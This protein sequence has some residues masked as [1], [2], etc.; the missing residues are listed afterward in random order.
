[1]INFIKDQHFKIP[2]LI[3]IIATIIALMGGGPGLFGNTMRIFHGAQAP[4]PP[5]APKPKT[6]KRKK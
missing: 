6:G 3:V 5:K 4:R 2:I 1:M